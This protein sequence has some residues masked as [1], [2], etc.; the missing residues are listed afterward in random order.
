MLWWH[1]Q[2]CQGIIFEVIFYDP[3]FSPQKQ[4]QE[5]YNQTHKNTLIVH[6]FKWP[7]RSS[8]WGSGVHILLDLLTIHTMKSL[9]G[10]CCGLYFKVLLPEVGICLTKCKWL[11]VR[12]RYRI[13]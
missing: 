2:N 9:M 12:M 5:R 3:F 1:S 4:A 7:L 11:G 8:K 6:S 13:E 10:V